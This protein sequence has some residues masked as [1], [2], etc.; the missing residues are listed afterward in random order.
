[1]KNLIKKIL[2]ERLML[3]YHLLLAK[4]A[5]VFYGNPSHKMTVIGVT[6][7]KGKTSTCNHIWATLSAGGIKT[8]IITTINVR[9]REEN[10]TNSKHMTMPGRFF[11]QSTLRKMYQAGCTHVVVETTSE[12]IKQHRA[13]YIDYSIAVFT[14]LTPEHLLSHGGSFEKYKEAKGKLF[15]FLYKHKGDTLVLANTD[16]KYAQYFLSFHATEKIT[17]GIIEQSDYQATKVKQHENSVTF[18]LKESAF[19]LNCIGTFN[20]YNALPAIVLARRFNVSEEQIHKG[21]SE[22]GTVP[23]RMQEIKTPRLNLGVPFRV[24]VDYAHEDTSLAMV[25]ETARTL[26][27]RNKVIVL[28][29]GQGG[30]RDKAKRARMGAV[31]ANLADI[32]IVA[33]EDPY[34]DDPVEIIEEIAIAA[35]S[36]G[37]VRDKDLF[38]AE[39]R[40]GGIAKALSLANSGDVVL[41]TGK[42][43]E[44]N[45]IVKGR[46]IDWDDRE[47][48]R[49]LLR[50][51]DK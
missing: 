24:F 15:A 42:G 44:Q 43:A 4:L 14:N 35:E 36:V 1:M 10:Q 25:L 32:V 18:K 45:M 37:K 7:T 22:L 40:R 17:Y 19:T 12:G 2:G 38:V 28:T 50:E 20:V 49:E 8:G 11:V 33:N 34:D 26:A 5:C 48:T 51:L 23:G 46:K 3:T 9:I 27:S 29:G 31:A 47:I 13:D 6:G 30:G 16:D 21:L 39:D 41:I